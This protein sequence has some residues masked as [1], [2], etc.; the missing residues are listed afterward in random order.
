MKKTKKVNIMANQQAISLKLDQDVLS[1]LNA[2]TATGHLKRNRLINE[3]IKTYI[4]ILDARR[5]WNAGI[6]THSGLMDY[7]LEVAVTVGSRTI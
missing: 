1:M 4:G 7:L 3:A 6:S 2:E 5:K